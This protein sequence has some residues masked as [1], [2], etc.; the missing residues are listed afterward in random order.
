MTED[1]DTRRRLDSQ[2]TV[3]LIVDTP[4]LR[5][6]RYL[7]DHLPGRSRSELQRWISE[8]RVTIGDAPVKASHSVRTSDRILVRVPAPASH[9]LL[10]EPLPLEVV[11]E[12]DKLLVISKP[13]GMVVHPAPGVR[14]GTLVNALLHRY[15]DL[16][17]SGADQRPGI[18]HRLDKDTSGLIVVARDEATRAQ[19]Q[20]Q[21][22][23]RT[24]RKRYLTLLEGRLEPAQGR[25]EA[26]I[27]RDPR[28]RKRMTVFPPH[29]GGRDA[30]TLYRVLEHFERFTLVEAEPK[31]G[32]T[33]QIRV[34]FS[35][36]RHPVVGDRVYGRRK[37]TLPCPRQFLHA[38]RLAFRLPSTGELAE[39]T[40]PLP[41]DLGQVLQALASSRPG[42]RH[43]DDRN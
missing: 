31:T 26:A 34:H 41:D 20:E 15:P 37:Q 10:P 22:K 19:L 11:Y 35:Y 23:E 21:F 18:V 13:P 42:E 5:L 39:F 12:D 16:D 14:A 9:E 24:V 30:V 32:R 3:E 2:G 27:G 17:R 28:H 40:A 25:I 7:A 43:E 1:A 33:H 38:Q 6:D 8:G 29:R 4:G 36:L